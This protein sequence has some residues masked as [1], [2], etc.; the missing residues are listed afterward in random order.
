MLKMALIPLFVLFFLI[1]HSVLPSSGHKENESPFNITMNPECGVL[2]G[3]CSEDGGRMI[4]LKPE[5]HWYRVEDI[6]QPHSVVSILVKDKAEHE[7][8]L[9]P[10]KLMNEYSLPS[11]TDDS[12]HFSFYN[13]TADNLSVTSKDFYKCGEYDFYCNP[14]DEQQCQNITLPFSLPDPPQSYYHPDPINFTFRLNISLECFGCDV[15]GGECHSALLNQF[16]FQCALPA[17]KGLSKKQKLVLGLGVGFCIGV[18]FAVIGLGIIMWRRKQKRV[19][20]RNIADPKY[21]NMEDPEG[22]SGYLGVLVFSYQ[23]LSEAT[24]NFAAEKELGHGGFGSVYHGKL[25]DGRE[26]AVKRLYEYNSKRV[27]EQF[28]NEIEILTHLRHKNL[29]SLYGCTSR[30]CRELLLVYEYIPNGT[31]AD[32]L[33]GEHAK[34]SPLTWPIRLS[35]A[36]ETAS[37]LAYLH[38]SE[39]VHRDVKTN[40]IL[41][42]KYFCV[43]VAD[44]GISRLFPNDVT[45]VSTAPQGT[46][47][48]VD[49]EYHQCYQL[50]SKSDVYSFGVVLIEL[51]SSLPAVDITRHRHEIN[52]ANLAICKIQTSAYNELIDQNLGFDSDTEVRTMT[53]AVAELAF[54]CLQQ[55]K[56]MRPTMDEVLERLR[57]IKD[58]KIQTQVVDCL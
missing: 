8:L 5:G 27:Q 44:F 52:L 10:C 56:E 45:H 9:D 16:Q 29:V 20:L 31:V 55:D 22:S 57:I 58:G 2:R 4:Q 18:L 13:Y 51:L 21:V 28:I 46:P 53:I 17:S 3:K 32:H 24:N 43:K 6:S 25:K 40:N 14:P 34:T 35:I 33:H 42:D 38:A 26:V 11:P 50:T 54:E 36:I 19:A 30:Q 41:L 47:G 1:S 7:D 23:D 12:S 39:I 48:Y 15:G 49:P 37:A